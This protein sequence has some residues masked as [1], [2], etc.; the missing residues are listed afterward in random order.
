MTKCIGL[1][2]HDKSMS[3]MLDGFIDFHRFNCKNPLCP[4]KK[5]V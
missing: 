1:Y 2:D 3:I 4:S 5:K